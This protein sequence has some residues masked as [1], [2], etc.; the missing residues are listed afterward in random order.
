MVKIMDANELYKGKS[1]QRNKGH[2]GMSM[3]RERMEEE[4]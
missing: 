4:E 1:I 3:F 2:W